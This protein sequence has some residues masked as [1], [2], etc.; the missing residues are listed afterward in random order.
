MQNLISIL[1]LTLI[2]MVSSCTP[3]SSM[4]SDGEL[5]NTDQN[6]KSNKRFDS[7]T[8]IINFYDVDT[9]QFKELEGSIVK[10]E[11]PL[12]KEK[13]IA[14]FDAIYKH[15][16]PIYI[17]GKDVINS[18]HSH[19]GYQTTNNALA[20]VYNDAQQGYTVHLFEKETNPDSVKNHAIQ[21]KEN[22][23]S[24]DSETKEKIMVL[25]EENPELPYKSAE[26][27]WQAIM[28]DLKTRVVNDLSTSEKSSV[29][30]YDDKITQEEEETFLSRVIEQQVI[31]NQRNTA[32]FGGLDYE[33]FRF[34]SYIIDVKKSN[35][36]RQA[37]KDG[38][39]D[40][41]A[42]IK[43]FEGRYE[44]HNEDR[45]FFSYYLSPNPGVNQKG[46][47]SS[48]SAWNIMYEFEPYIQ[49]PKNFAFDL[50]SPES[51]AGG[52]GSYSNST[53]FGV[54]LKALDP[55]NSLEGQYSAGTSYSYSFPDYYFSTQH[56]KNID[57]NKHEI[58]WSW[59]PGN[60]VYGAYDTGWGIMNKSGAPWDDI[61]CDES[62]LPLPMRQLNKNAVEVVM[63]KKRESG[64]ESF[65]F[66][67]GI[68][69]VL[70]D[71]HGK[72]YPIL[73][74]LFGWNSIVDRQ[75][76]TVN[77][78]KTFTFTTTSFDE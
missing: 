31:S 9:S 13:D 42:M 66:N 70:H 49:Y 29:I 60:C 33:Q 11:T 71:I 15:K 19:H 46:Y 57:N 51:Q 67:Y 8:H 47:T 54:K 52:N 43:V 48:T 39:Y 73:L 68:R 27:Y 12:Q 77:I 30:Y 74:G 76:R 26:E 2:L 23:F 72:N 4:L 1:L 14:L 50:W 53:N 20:L 41:R 3:K 18:I 35:G 7:K 56:D 17:K 75:T 37:W 78:N 28:P 22:F 69:C 44:G 5:E 63:S 38:E 32:T 25:L 58:Y 65:S 40:Y 10:L 21:L 64:E 61:P 34:K 59:T 36:Y 62:K 24:L 45:L 6:G 16:I 55:L